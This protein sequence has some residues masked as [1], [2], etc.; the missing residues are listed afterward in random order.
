VFGE[1]AQLAFERLNVITV[2][3]NVKPEDI[4]FIIGKKGKQ[5]G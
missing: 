5:V 2:T 3:V 4:G 1:Q